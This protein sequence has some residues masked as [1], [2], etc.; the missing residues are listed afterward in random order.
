[1]VR[2]SRFPRAAAFIVILAS[3]ALS[4]GAAAQQSL[5]LIL[6]GGDYFNEGDKD[7][8][9]RHLAAAGIPAG[10]VQIYFQ[11]PSPDKVSRM[12][13]IR[14]FVAHEVDALVVYGASTA[15]EASQETDKMP[16]VFLGAHDP[17]K[18]GLVQSMEK[19]GRNLTGVSASTSVAFLLDNIVEIAGTGDLG[20]AHSSNSLNSEE[21]LKEIR[22]LSGQRGLKPVFVDV[23]G[24]TT[25]EMKSAFRGAK[26]IYLAVGSFPLDRARCSVGD[27]GKPVASQSACTGAEGVVLALVPDFQEMLK[28]GAALTARILRGEDPGRIP[29]SPLKK[30]SFIINLKE[31]KK[32]GLKIPFPVL[33]RATEVVK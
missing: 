14:K 30:I 32:H 15:R 26:F 18:Q 28:E 20:V 33:S 23:E 31:A 11:R 2:L 8:F 4:T 10:S 7:D 9:S 6:P 27:L 19:P 25:E 17:V 13:S 16:I 21:Q 3:L 29:V 5:G 24:S 1:M 22:E 12:N